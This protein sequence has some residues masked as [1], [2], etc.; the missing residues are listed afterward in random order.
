ME[1]LYY[2]YLVVVFDCSFSTKKTTF[3]SWGRFK[4]EFKIFKVGCD[5][6]NWTS[7]FDVLFKVIFR[8]YPD[9]N[10]ITVGPNNL[11]IVGQYILNFLAMMSLICN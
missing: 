9:L 11:S 3:A 4:T 8:Y 7:R 5:R 6:N 1:I 2:N 10:Q